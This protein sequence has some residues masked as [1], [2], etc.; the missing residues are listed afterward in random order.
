MNAVLQESEN[1][2]MSELVQK[3]ERVQGI[4]E[5]SKFF[6]D[7]DYIEKQFELTGDIEPEPFVTPVFHRSRSCPFLS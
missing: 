1:A 2:F 3:V 6:R 4:R 7:L 5:E